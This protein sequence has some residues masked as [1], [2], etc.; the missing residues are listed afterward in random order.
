MPLLYSQY[1]RLEGEH[2]DKITSLA[3]STNG[4][5]LAVASLDGKL[6][7][8]STTTGKKLYAVESGPSNIAMLS[9][10][11]TTPSEN[12]L[13]CGLANGVVI[14]VHADNEVHQ[15]DLVV[16]GAPSEVSL[17]NHRAHWVHLG[18]I[19]PPPS[20]SANREADVIVT[21]LAWARTKYSAKT[22]LIAYLHH[23][24]L[25][26]DATKSKMAHFLYIK[27]LVGSMSISRNGNVIVVSNLN[28][29]FDIYHLDDSTLD[30][31]I[32]QPCN[33]LRVPVT[34]IHNGYA[35]LGRSTSEQAHI[36]DTKD[37]TLLNTLQ[38]DGIYCSLLLQ[39]MWA[40]QMQ[41]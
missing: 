18:H 17:W 30:G 31:P 23:G 2:K 38:H 16:T 12:Q 36:W 22:L 26:W 27:T 34:F 20:I 14:S 3:F 35:F 39:V 1:Q 11:W 24:I 4:S 8:W 21:S 32:M 29:G 33:G 13:L 9:I 19:H 7:V 41:I 15:C 5:Y 6:S 40:Q 10:V 28:D 37:R 25:L